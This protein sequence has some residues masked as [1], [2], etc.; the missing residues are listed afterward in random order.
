MRYFLS[1]ARGGKLSRAEAQ[2][3]LTANLGLPG[4]GSLMGGRVVGY[5]QVLVAVAGLGLTLIFG[6]FFLVW[7][8]Q[9]LEQLRDPEGDPFATLSAIWMRLRWALGGV[10]LFGIAWVW[11]LVT[12]LSILRMPRAE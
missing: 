1:L 2:A 8:I 9:N 7:A 5:W 6:L 3:C 12:S 11:A 4:A 10:G